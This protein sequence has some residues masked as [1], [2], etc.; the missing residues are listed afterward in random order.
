[1]GDTVKE[2]LNDT[3]WSAIQDL[4]FVKG[5]IP[6]SSLSKSSARMTKI[7]GFELITSLNSTKKRIRYRETFKTS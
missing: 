4:V 1:M 6:P 3:P 7:F 2:F 5:L